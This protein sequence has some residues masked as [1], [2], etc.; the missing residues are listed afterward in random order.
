MLVSE[1]NFSNGIIEEDYKYNSF[2]YAQIEKIAETKKIPKHIVKDVKVTALVFPFRVNK[3]V[4]NE[5]IDWNNIPND[6]MFRL[7]F[8]MSGMIGEKNFERLSYL[9]EHECDKWVIQDAVDSIREGL[10]P[11]PSGQ[12]TKNRPSIG[13]NQLQGFQHKYPETLLF[14]PSQAQYCHAYCSYCFRWAQFTAKSTRMNSKDSALLQDYLSQHHEVT[15][16]LLTGGDPMVMRTHKMREYLSALLSDTCKHVTNI[17]IGTKSLAFWPARFVTDS[18]AFELCELFKRA[19]ERGKNISIMA[20]FSH[21]KELSSTLVRQA[22]KNLRDAGTTIRTQAPLLRGINDD[23]DIWVAMWK[24]QVNLGLI[25]YYMFI[26]RDTGARNYFDVTLARALEIFSQA[27]KRVSGL[28]KTIRGPVM[29]ADPG[30]IQVMGTA[31]IGGEKVFCLQFI[32]ARN[33]AWINQIFFAKYD[34][35]AT[36]ID[37]LK[38]ALGASKFFWEENF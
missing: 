8:P 21:P 22:I 17:R 10:N 33:P 15:D 20:H 37:Q 18:D 4:L 31:E 19:G 34:S 27:Y 9:L 2:Q 38:P 13:E 35:Q 16:V 29:S 23:P 30:K 7:L 3:Y 25:P 5:L 1:L 12:M 24:Q 36:W 6:P 26:D 11:H 28:C 14:F 32:Q